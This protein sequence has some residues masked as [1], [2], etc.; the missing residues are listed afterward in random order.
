MFGPVVPPTTD[1][2]WPSPSP[3]PSSS[4]PPPSSPP[5]LSL[6]LSASLF[7][8]C[9]LEPPS[10]RSTADAHRASRYS[11]FWTT[12]SR[13]RALRPL[14]TM[15][16]VHRSFALS[17]P[18]RTFPAP[19]S[20]STPLSMAT[21]DPTPI[22][23]AP[24]ISASASSSAHASSSMHASSSV[25]SAPTSSS[26]PMPA[27]VLTS[28]LPPPPPA[29][30]R[31]VLLGTAPPSCPPQLWVAEPDLTVTPD[32]SIHKLPRPIMHRVPRPVNS[33][34][35]FKDMVDYLA[36]HTPCQYSDCRVL[37]KLPHVG[38]VPNNFWVSSPNMDFVPEVPIHNSD[39]EFSYNA[40]SMLGAFELFKWP[41]SYN[42]AVPHAIAAPIN[43][44]LLQCQ[45]QDYAMCGPP[46]Q[47]QDAEVCFMNVTHEQFTVSGTTER[48]EVG[49]INQRTYLR[50]MRALREAQTVMAEVPSQVWPNP[51]CLPIPFS[52]SF[53]SNLGA[54]P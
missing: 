24:P 6:L 41:A 52:M 22:S 12:L 28:L 7:P 30:R 53:L 43:P 20:A 3:S 49:Q 51:D 36:P 34:Q 40:D 19:A 5:L 42:N 15:L 10:T 8:G 33:L 29:I 50:L 21:P 27:P 17:D 23:Q 13:P 54:P 38:G 37:A 9:S 31:D 35:Q 14:P 26:E 45:H 48:S 16:P 18:A 44:V 25:P 46:Y 2:S 47:W 39:V 4:S 32:P 1:V 11:R